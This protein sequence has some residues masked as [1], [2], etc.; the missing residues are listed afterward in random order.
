MMMMLMW[1]L[2]LLLLMMIEWA[3]DRRLIELLYGLIEVLV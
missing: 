1:L 2:L 3:V